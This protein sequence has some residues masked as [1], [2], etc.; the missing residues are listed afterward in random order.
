M[1]FTILIIL[2]GIIGLLMTLVVLL[3]S[4]QGGG[5]AGIA[6]GS[7]TQILGSR[8]APD[9]L[10]KITWSLATVFIVL[11]VLTNFAIDKDQ[12][13]GSVIQGSSQGTEQI[14]PAPTEGETVPAPPPAGG[15]TPAGE[16]PVNPAN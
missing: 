3:Q 2:I 16:T 7:T 9:V 15:T 5:L 14:V 10:E 6:S 13:G 12:Q 8:Q 4:G 1:I 11:C